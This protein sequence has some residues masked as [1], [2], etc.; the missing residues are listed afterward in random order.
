MK[1]VS[2]PIAAGCELTV[3]PGALT[4]NNECKFDNAGLQQAP[5]RNRAGLV[6]L[7]GAVHR[8]TEMSLVFAFDSHRWRQRCRAVADPTGGLC[9]GRWLL[10]RSRHAA[11]VSLTSAA[12]LFGS[13]GTRLFHRGRAEAL[14]SAIE[15][16]QRVF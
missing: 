11:T 3:V 8:E 2:K 14:K 5:G 15:Q 6:M 4:A 9:D 1:L 7:G 16:H 12:A 13:G 10:Y